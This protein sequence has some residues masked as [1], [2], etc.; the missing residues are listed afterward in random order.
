MIKLRDAGID[1]RGARNAAMR[2]LLLELPAPV[3]ADSLN[4]NYNVTDK[5]RRNAG[6][7]FLDYATRRTNQAIP[8]EF[9]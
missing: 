5:H 8:Q 3:V 6:A 7:T 2:A 4:H 9:I 1:L